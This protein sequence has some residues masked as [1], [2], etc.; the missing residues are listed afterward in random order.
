MSDEQKVYVGGKGATMQ[1]VHEFAVERVV[2]QVRRVHTANTETA[3]KNGHL[4]CLT[5]RAA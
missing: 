4:A 3:I 1:S 5:K 2:G